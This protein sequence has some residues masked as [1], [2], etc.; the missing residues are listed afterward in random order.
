VPLELVAIHSSLYVPALF[1]SVTWLLLE[2]CLP[3]I[4]VASR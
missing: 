3:R 1:V 2:D 4:W